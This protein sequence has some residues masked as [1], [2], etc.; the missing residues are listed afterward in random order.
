[1]EMNDLKNDLIRHV[2]ARNKHLQLD[3]L[4]GFTF[5]DLMAYTDPTYREYFLRKKKEICSVQVD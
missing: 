4:R 2:R 5:E 1:M 3:V